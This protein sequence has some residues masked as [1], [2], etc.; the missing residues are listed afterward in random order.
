MTCNEEKYNKENAT[1][2]NSNSYANI[3]N[4]LLEMGFDADRVRDVFQSL[5]PNKVNNENED[6]TQNISDTELDVQLVNAVQHLLKMS[7]QSK[8]KQKVKHHNNSNSNSNSNNSNEEQEQYSF[9]ASL[10][11]SF[12]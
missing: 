11:F 7:M 9:K 8:N 6:Q 5:N 2:A 4:D 3:S 1:T 10:E 12:C